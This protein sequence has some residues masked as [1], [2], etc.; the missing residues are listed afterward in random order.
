MPIEQRIKAAVKIRQIF[1]FILG[2]A[3]FL[4]I[5]PPAHAEHLPI[6]TYSVADGLPRD[7]VQ[8]IAQDSRG[9][10]GFALT[11][12][13]RVLTVMVL[14]ISQFTMVCP[15]A[16]STIFS[17]RA[18]VRFGLRPMVD[19]PDSTQP[20]LPVQKRILYLLHFCRIICVQKKSLFYLKTKAARSL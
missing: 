18:T 3:C 19:L 11:T 13:S 1:S 12:V 6:K 20:G 4:Q 14:R 9:F 5:S 7:S 17:K 10:Y 2:L 16:T 8:K 15:T